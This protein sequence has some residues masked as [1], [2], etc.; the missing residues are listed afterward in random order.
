MARPPRCSR[1]AR[2]GRAGRGWLAFTCGLALAAGC[3]DDGPDVRYRIVGLPRASAA[4]CPAPTDAPPVVPGATRVRLTFRDQ[5]AAGIGGLRCDVVL[6]VG[7]ATPTVAVPR[8]GE[9]VAMWVEYFDDAGALLARGERRGVALDAGDTVT[10]MAAPAGDYACAPVQATVGRAFHSATL[11]PDGKVL[12]LGGVTG[13]LAGDGT[14]SF[15]P[16]DG[17]YAVA[18]AELYDPVAGRSVPVAIPGLMPRAFHRAVVVGADD[19]GVHLLVLGGL[20]VNND[21]TSPGNVAAVPGGSGA[22]PWQ[23]AGVDISRGRYGARGLPVEYLTYQPAT[24]SFTRVELGAAGPA[25]R[26]EASVGASVDGGRLA[27]VG[28]RTATGA[29]SPL[30]EAVRPA[31][32]TVSGTVNGRPRVGATVT[33]LPGGDA[34]VAGGDV[35]ADLAGVRTVDHLAGLD[36][37]PTLDP[38][39]GGTAAT[40]RAYHAAALLGDHVVLVGGL[41]LGATGVEDQGPAMLAARISNT[42]LA[43]AAI[44][45]AMASAVAYPGAL[46]LHDGGVLAAGGASPGG[47]CG[48]TILCPAPSSLRFDT[49]AMGPRAAPA[50][51]LGVARYGHQLVRLADGT[52]L[53]TGGFTVDPTDPSHL[54][55][56]TVVEQFEA[57]RAVDDPLADLNL[58]RA[59]GDVARDA[60]GAAIAA[61][62]VVGAPAPDAAVDA[63]APDAAIDAP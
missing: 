48:R 3:G 16:D 2:S 57:H 53:V 46:T 12:L 26:V 54:R 52:V 44:D 33:L 63:S 62:T 34:I 36:G 31:D 38:G 6:A 42:T 56:T 60:G 58:V 20:G 14:A 29:A 11:L 39:P 1:S 8:R 43:A 22:P 37:A 9:P 35:G 50:G 13:A 18:S 40:N 55:A 7:G 17:A 25:L 30:V 51:S 61:C 47:V 49:D 32:G 4:G 23:A 10:I 15:A 27:V 19:T 21:P 45:T 28:G 41:H 5:T 59:P 24:R